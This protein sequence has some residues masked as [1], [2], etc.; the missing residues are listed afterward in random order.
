[1]EYFVIAEILHF[2]ALQPES[3]TSSFRNLD[4]D[5][6]LTAG[7]MFNRAYAGKRHLVFQ[8]CIEANGNG[9]WGRLFVIATPKE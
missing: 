6:V 8:T 7:A 1:V 5:E 4:R 2:Q 3:V 9:S